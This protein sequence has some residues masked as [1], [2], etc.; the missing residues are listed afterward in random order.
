MNHLILS[1]RLFGRLLLRELDEA[2]LAHLRQPEVAS[3]L[4]ELGVVVPAGGADSDVIE[5]MAAEYCACFLVGPGHVPLVQSVWEQ[6]ANDQQ[7]GLALS[8]LARSAGLSFD[9]EQARS[10]PVDHLGCILL[11]WAKLADDWPEA[12]E[13]VIRRHLP[14]AQ[15]PLRRLAQ[16]SGFYG[17]LSR[18]TLEL[19]DAVRSTPQEEQ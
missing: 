1:A 15:A 14:W 3:A 9:R 17:Q 13:Y 18:A 10:A 19:I 4:A 5:E 2:T 7:S 8:E 11:L 6:G 16:D 12:S